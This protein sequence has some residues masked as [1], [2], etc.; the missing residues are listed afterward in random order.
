MLHAWF[1]FGILL[2]VC[3]YCCILIWSV[4]AS[5]VQH[6]A[7]NVP[8]GDPALSMLQNTV[9]QGRPATSNSSREQSDDEDEVEGEAETN[10]MD[11]SDVKRQRR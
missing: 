3:I 7:S 6:T 11:P 5:K 10:D 2:C 1:Q 4:N 9:T 8:S